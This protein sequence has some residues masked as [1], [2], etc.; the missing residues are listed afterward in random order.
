MTKIKDMAGKIE[1]SLVVGF[2]KL[3]LLTSLTEGYDY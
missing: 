2:Y 1:V 3:R